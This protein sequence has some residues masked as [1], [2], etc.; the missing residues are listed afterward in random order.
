MLPIGVIGFLRM[1]RLANLETLGY[2]DTNIGLI[3]SIPFV[4]VAGGSVVLLVMGVLGRR[5]IG[6]ATSIAVSLRRLPS[7]ILAVSLIWIVRSAGF[8]LLVVPG[9]ILQVRL[10]VTVP[11]LMVEA[12]GPIEALRRAWTLSRPHQ[13]A[14]FVAG[15]FVW[16]LV[17]PLMIGAV[18]PFVD[19]SAGSDG[20]PFHG[21]SAASIALASTLSWLATTIATVLSATLAT[22]LYAQITEQGHAEAL[23]QVAAAESPG[24]V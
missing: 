16:L 15:V 8:L 6:I 20:N 21:L 17:G 10:C 18:L 2:F 12:V 11:A 13:L 9:I 23:G 7:L 1:Q 5:E 22:V 14:I 4:A 24:T 19:F 3:A